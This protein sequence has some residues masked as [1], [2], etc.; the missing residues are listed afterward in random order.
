MKNLNINCPIGGTGYGITSLNILKELFKINENI[1]LFP[2]GNN[3]TFNSDDEKLLLQQC[4]QNNQH[5]EYTAPCLKIWHQNDLASSIGKGK[6]YA[7]P[8]FEL[9]TFSELEKHHL[10]YPDHLFVASEWGK[11]ILIHNGIYKSIT[12]A[13]LGVD[14]SIFKQSSKIKLENQP[15]IFF[16]IGKWEKRKSQ[17]FLI[18]AFETTF[19]I[20][21][22]V[23]LWL[24]PYNPFLNKEEE[25]NWLKLADNSKLSS[26]IKV[27]NRVETQYDLASFINH[28]DC[29]VF[30]SRAEGWNNEIIECMAMNKPI[31]TTFY[32]AHTEYCNENNSYLVYI[33]EKEPAYDN[34]WFNG[35]GNWAKLGNDQLEQTVYYM[36]KVYNDNIRSNP[37]GLATAEKYSWTNTANIISSTIF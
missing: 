23:E 8:F 31:I 12:V 29:G 3:M 28:G 21:D 35:Q 25:Q 20:N 26:K 24:M 30:L 37:Q 13:P 18:K 4:L 11:N 17:D 6:Y 16:H 32:S 33:E 9:D 22:N 27:F 1:A 19:D 14:T 7:F 10:N 36:K 34:K 15:Y 2:V 5:F